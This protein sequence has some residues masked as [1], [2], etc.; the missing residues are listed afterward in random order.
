EDTVDFLI[1]G[2]G[3]SRLKSDNVL[4]PRRGYSWEA[5]LRGSP[6]LI[7]S[8][9]FARIAAGARA[10][11][12]LGD[13]A[14]I[15][16]RAQLGAMTVD[17]FSS[18]P[19]AERFFTG[20]DQ[21]VRGYDYQELAP[22]DS[23]GEVV[24]GQFLAVAGIEIDYLFA[25]NF[26]AAVFVDAGNAD[27]TFPPDPKVGAGIGFRWRSPVGMLR[28]DLAHPFDDPLNNYRLH[29]SIGPDL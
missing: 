1:P 18:L 5:D 8:T 22:V 7:S 14:R 13:K 29:I 17:D 19:T 16:G 23:S 21:S 10:V 3:L 9:R 28:V 27:D 24:G 15:L 25:G 4:F 26:G 11:F 20:G 12:P 2:I 6:G